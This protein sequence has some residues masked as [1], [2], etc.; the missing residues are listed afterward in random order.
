MRSK[1]LN[2][3]KGLIMTASQ[4]VKAQGLKSLRQM[5]Q[6]LNKPERTL[7][8]WHK[9]DPELFRLALLGCAAELGLVT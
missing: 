5:A 7:F 8:H 1:R 6:M 3:W 4:Q 2:I 9:N